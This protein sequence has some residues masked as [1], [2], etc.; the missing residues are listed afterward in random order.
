[1][2]GLTPEEIEA[3]Q[4]LE[5]CRPDDTAPTEQDRAD[6]EWVKT[7]CATAPIDSMFYKKY[8]SLMIK[9][10]KKHNR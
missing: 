9:Y 5:D 7:L 2:I 1:M 4:W 3:L 8:R 10:W 6:W